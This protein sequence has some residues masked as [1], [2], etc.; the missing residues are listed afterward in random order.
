[1]AERNVGWALLLFSYVTLAKSEV[2]VE[3]WHVLCYNI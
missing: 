3:F 2:V 1:M